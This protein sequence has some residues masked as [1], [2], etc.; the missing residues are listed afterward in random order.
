MI[1]YLSLKRKKPIK[2]NVMLKH[3]TIPSQLILSFLLNK[4]GISNSYLLTPSSLLIFLAQSW[5][6]Q[7]SNVPGFS[8]FL[9]LSDEVSTFDESVQLYQPNPNPKMVIK[10]TKKELA[11]NIINNFC[12]LFMIQFNTTLLIFVVTQII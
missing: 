7:L 8:I 2:L 5:N 11:P 3:A 1:N 12:L 4:S 10:R 6:F 9:Y